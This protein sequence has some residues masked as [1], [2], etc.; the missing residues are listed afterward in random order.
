[1]NAGIAKCLLP[2][3]RK[4]Y[5]RRNHDDGMQASRYSVAKQQTKKQIFYRDIKPFESDTKA[6][7]E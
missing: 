6:N 2:Y 3:F 7:L 4:Q 1:M 5:Y